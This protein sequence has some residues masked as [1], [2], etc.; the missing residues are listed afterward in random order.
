M[1]DPDHHH[2][3]NDFDM[4]NIAILAASACTL[5]AGPA[6]A[7]DATEFTCPEGATLAALASDAAA[8]EGTRIV[9][10]AA[11]GTPRACLVSTSGGVLG[12]D[13]LAL[14][15]VAVVSAGVVTAIVTSSDDDEPSSR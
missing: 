9:K 6:I 12:M 7:Q 13:A 2:E 14:A 1:V 10:R 5:L 11:P 8:P 4:R 15:G 3:S